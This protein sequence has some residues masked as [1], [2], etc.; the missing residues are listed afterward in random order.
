MRRAGSSFV[1][2]RWLGQSGLAVEVD[3]EGDALL[4]TF[5]LAVAC[6]AFLR[7]GVHRLHR[8]HSI[9]LGQRGELLD[10]SALQALVVHATLEERRAPPGPVLGRGGGG[11]GAGGGGKERPPVGNTA[12]GR[13]PGFL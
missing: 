6:V 13:K 4:R 7:F 11:G 2:L 8:L 1:L 12:L 3:A 10:R 9:L 5:G